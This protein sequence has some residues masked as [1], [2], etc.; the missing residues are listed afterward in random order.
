MENHDLSL[1]L[2]MLCRC[3]DHT[4]RLPKLEGLTVSQRKAIEDLC[5][6]CSDSFRVTAVKQH[7]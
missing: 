6:L 1:D 7:K 2:G 3:C 4:Y 5:R